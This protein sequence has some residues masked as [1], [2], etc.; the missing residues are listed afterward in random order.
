MT[1]MFVRHAKG[2]DGNTEAVEC[3]D[4]DWAGRFDQLE[5]VHDL[6]ERVMAGEPM[7]AG[8]CPKCGAL[9]HAVPGPAPELSFNY[10]NETV[11]SPTI[12]G[13]LNWISCLHGELTDA[14]L[15]PSGRCDKCGDAFDTVSNETH[16]Q[17]MILAKAAEGNRTLVAPVDP[18]EAA[19]RAAGW[20]HGGDNRG[21][22]Y[23]AKQYDSWKEAVSWAGDGGPNDNGPVYDTWKE[24]CEAQGIEVEG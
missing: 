14:G 18:H 10:Q 13:L 2:D 9:C 20:T 16:Q 22:I 8:Q 3:Q 15:L 17:I 1:E 23:H 4:C 24:C 12:G 19:A 11:R 7:P 5:I 21:Y 6:E